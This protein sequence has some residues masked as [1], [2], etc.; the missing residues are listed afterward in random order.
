MLWSPSLQEFASAQSAP[1]MHD[2]VARLLSNV[3]VTQITRPLAG[4]AADEP[5]SKTQGVRRV[6]LIDAVLR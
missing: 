5:R 4:G 6:Q 1:F 3:A 2:P